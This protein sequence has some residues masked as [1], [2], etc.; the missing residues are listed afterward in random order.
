MRRNSKPEAPANAPK[1]PNYCLH[2]P[3][4]RAF[5]LLNGSMRY[6]GK[7]GTSESKERYH[8]LLAE[9]VANGRKPVLPESVRENGGATVAELCEQYAVYAKGYYRSHDGTSGTE[10]ENIRLVLRE[11][12]Q[13]YGDGLV[14]DFGPV[15]LKTLRHTFVE[16]DVAWVTA[17]RYTKIVWRVFKWAVAE[18]LCAESVYRTLK[19]IEPLKRGR[20]L[21]RETEPVKPVPLA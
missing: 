7:Y 14:R 2:K 15:Q 6:V 18:G 12:A 19:C 5:V 1:D 21:A 9:W 13:L 16:R 3:S 10:W 17:N 8:K 20:C 4:G 11:L